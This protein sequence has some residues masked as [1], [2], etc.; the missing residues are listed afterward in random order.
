[1]HARERGEHCALPLESNATAMQHVL[2]VDAGHQAKIA[3]QCQCTAFDTVRQMTREC[4]THAGLPDRVWHREV[5]EPFDH[6]LDARIELAGKDARHERA[7][8]AGFVLQRLEHRVGLCAGSIGQ[9]VPLDVQPL[10]L[11]VTVA[12]DIGCLAD[13]A[14]HTPT[15]TVDLDAERLLMFARDR[16]SVV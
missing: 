13:P 4:D 8:V 6:R 15:A 1:M 9:G 12:N 2:G 14:Q 3:L 16:K 5:T 7:A 10:A 11:G